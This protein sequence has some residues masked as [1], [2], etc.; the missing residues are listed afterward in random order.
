MRPFDYTRPANTDDVI[1]LLNAAVRPYAGGTDLL[2]RMKLD[3]DTPAQL[4]DLKTADLPKGIQKTADGLTIG[5]LT[6]LTEIEQSDLLKQSY[7]LLA[8]AASL[9]ATPQVRNRATLGGNLLQRPRC[10]YYRN[11]HVDCWLK[12]GY[13]CPARTGRNE[14]HALF[15]GDPCWAVH[16]SDLAACL[17]ALEARV[18]VRGQT[19]ERELPLSHFFQLPTADRRQETVITD[20]ELILSISIPALPAGA[21]S[22]YLKAMDRKVWAFALVGAAVIVRVEANQITDSRLVLSGV[23][24]IPWRLSLAE[25][26]LQGRNPSQTDFHA[27][28]E[29]ALA[30]AEPLEHN[31]YKVPLAKR[32]LQ[33]ALV[34]LTGGA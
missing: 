21:K 31:I 32:L 1:P 13:D 19:G 14:H 6:T 34:E 4:V 20:D 7:P 11:A 26:E 24:P 18:T 8:E 25:A 3:L 9:A 30:E 16:P 17:L 12:G 33:K 29:T 28:A 23:A 27:I 2:T 22:T 5:A 15:G 10:W